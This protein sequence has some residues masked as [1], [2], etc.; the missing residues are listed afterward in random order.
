MR[1]AG[2]AYLVVGL[3][4]LTVTS[5]CI[6]SMDED[7]NSDTTEENSI[8]KAKDIERNEISSKIN[9]AIFK[10][11]IDESSSLMFGIENPYYTLR[12]SD[13][14]YKPIKNANNAII[15]PH[16]ETSR[17]GFVGNKV[18]N[19][20]DNTIVASKIDYQKGSIIFFSDNPIFRGFWENGKLLVAN[21][22]FFK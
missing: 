21:A 15:I 17:N 9:G 1:R 6:S 7:G 11:E 8:T 14:L 19:K 2:L 18:K 10:C 5:G 16:H 20:S 12:L 3:Y 4:I 13:E 22:I